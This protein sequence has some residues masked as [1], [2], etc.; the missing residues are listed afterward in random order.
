MDFAQFENRFSVSVID[1]KYYLVDIFKDVEFSV[2]DLH[3]LV[4]LEEKLGGKKLP[5]LVVCPSSVTT[6]VELM[7]E[8]AKNENNPY[9]SADSFVIN[10]MSQKI[11]ANFYLR[12]NIPERPTKFF[13]SHQEAE[14][15]LKQFI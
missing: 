13:T 9:S 12:I 6:N 5:V 14:T 10:S 8:L 15:W 7:R 2:F 3:E 11:L 1:N 4:K